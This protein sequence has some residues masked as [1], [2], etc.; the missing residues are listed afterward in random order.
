MDFSTRKN[1][2]QTFTIW[3]SSP[4]IIFSLEKLD[5]DLCAEDAVDF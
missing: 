5:L 2:A 1:R 4:K 3:L